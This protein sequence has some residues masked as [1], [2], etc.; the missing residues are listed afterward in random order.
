MSFQNAYKNW[1]CS[2]KIP[3][4]LDSQLVRPCPSY[5]NNVS[6]QCPYLLP[7]VENQ[8]AGEPSFVC[9]GM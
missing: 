1:V 3:Y 6:Q 4:Y 5:C 2:L 8:Y 7:H 9:T